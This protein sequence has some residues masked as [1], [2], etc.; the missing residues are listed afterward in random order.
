MSERFEGDVLAIHVPYTLNAFVNKD[1]SAAPLHLFSTIIQNY[2]FGRVLKSMFVPTFLV[3]TEVF[4]TLLLA[5]N[6]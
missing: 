1:M 6:I 5:K 2:G 3:F 4:L